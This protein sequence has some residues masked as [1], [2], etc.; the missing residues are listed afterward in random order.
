MIKSLALFALVLASAPALAQPPSATVRTADLDLA[1]PTG[2]ARLDR[3]IDH[4]VEEICG[5]AVAA[6]LDGLAAIGRCRAE[7]MKSVSG[8]R[9][10][11]IAHAGRPA[12]I[13]LKG[14]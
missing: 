6:D 13:A 12:A 1:T 3:R 7:T 11:L 9:A 8:R 14:R 2:V 5:T 10:M 4:A